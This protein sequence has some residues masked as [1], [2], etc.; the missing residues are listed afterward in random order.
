L[1]LGRLKGRSKR[2]LEEA[3][4]KFEAV[5]QKLNDTHKAESRRK[6]G[7]GT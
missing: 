4:V 3:K 7:K 2:K 6:E 5:N 1:R